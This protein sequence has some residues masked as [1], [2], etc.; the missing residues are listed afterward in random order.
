[1]IRFSEIEYKRPDFEA[2]KSLITEATQK[3]REAKS[4]AEIR[5]AYFT[6]QEA[7]DAADSMYTVAHIR[8]TINTADLFYDAEMKWLREESAKTI[9][10]Y[11]A[12][13]KALAESAFLKELEKEFGA[14]FFRMIDAELMTSDERIVQE[15]I[16]EGELRQAYQKTTA[17]AT[18]EFRGEQCNFYGLLKH[19]Q[20][21]DRT[22]RKEAFEAW[23]KLY[24]QIS[25]ELEAQFADAV[26]TRNTKAKKMGFASY[27]DMAY[28]ARHRFDYTKEDACRGGDVRSTAETSRCR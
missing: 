5:D 28:I 9:P 1:M 23:A 19:M 2:L 8:N 25:G 24:E 27:T 26:K 4:V 7:E 15:A 16:R 6:V 10:Q 18:T 22:E 13:Q 3:V 11:N 12:W 20:S 14:Q 17:A 21:T